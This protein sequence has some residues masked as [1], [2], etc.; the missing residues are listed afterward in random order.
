MSTLRTNTIQGL[1][2]PTYV[3]LPQ[4]IVDA[5]FFQF[6]V[7]GG[8]SRITLKPGSITAAYLAPG[9]LGPNSVG[10]INLQDGCVTTPKLADQAV[11]TAKLADHS[12]TQ[13]KLALGAVTTTELAN[14]AVLAVNIGAGAVGSAAIAN[15]SILSTHL[16][17]QC[18]K[19]ANYY[20]LSITNGAYAPASITSDK[21][22]ASFLAS[23][24]N[25]SGVPTG[26]VISSGLQLSAAVPS[27][28][29]NCD[30]GQYN[31]VTYAALYTAVGITW[32][33]GDG[34]T[35]FNVPDLQGRAIIGH[36]AG[37]GLTARTVG[38]NGGEET[39]LLLVSEMPSHNHTLIDGGHSH[40]LNDPGHAHGITAAATGIVISA[41]YTGVNLSDP[42]HIHTLANERQW[43]GLYQSGSNANFIAQPGDGSMVTTRNTTGITLNDPTHVH[44]IADPSHVH[45]VQKGTTQITIAG[46]HTG[47]TMSNSGGGTAHN[48]MM[49]FAVCR[50][51]IKT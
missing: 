20:P 42:G 4:G 47:I 49:P 25:Q 28:F 23:L 39:H 7:I 17:S 14:G 34:S 9:F 21:L 29:L 5:T 37:A 13:V 2:D 31:R 51:F 15:S 32:G 8:E 38:Q 26:T 27:G 45:T 24:Q 41:A 48:N 44:A 46:A 18:V 11:T 33:P 19:T 10:T 3:S 36:G 12:V 50:M 1:A 40:G 35:T 30:G 43:Q 6:V 22:D 16:A